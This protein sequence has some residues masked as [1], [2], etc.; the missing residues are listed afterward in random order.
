MSEP[1]EKLIRRCIQFY[2]EKNDVISEL[3]MSSL[4]THECGRIERVLC[5]TIN[6]FLD[7]IA[8]GWRVFYP[9]A[10]TKTRRKPRDNADRLDIE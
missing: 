1:D 6:L 10:P 2:I 4:P 9:A 3:Y 7:D 5:D 8:P